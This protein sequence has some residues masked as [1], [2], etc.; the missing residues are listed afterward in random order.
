MDFYEV[1]VAAPIPEALTYSVQESE[2]SSLEAGTSVI[3]PL[4][5]RKAH[6]VV[7]RTTTPPPEI[8]LKSITA[9]NV[10]RPPLPQKHLQWLVWLSQYYFYPLGQVIDMAFPPLKRNLKPRKSSKSSI[11]P[12]L[13]STSPHP[14]L[15]SEQQTVVESIQKLS[16]FQ[17]HLV[18][19]VTGSGKTE[20]YLQLIARL[21]KNG[22]SALVLVPEI[23]LTPQLVSRFAERFPD[24]VA[25]IHSHLTEREKTDQ[26]WLAHTGER[27]VLIGARS[28]LFCPLPH[29]GMIILDEEHEPSF[30]QDE[31]LKYHARDAA[32]MLAKMMGIPIVLGSA[33]P[34]LETYQRARDGIYH[35]HTMKT[36]VQNR[37]LPIV[38]VVD[39]REARRERR[40]TE[41]PLPFWLSEPLHEE[42][43][44]TFQQG[45]QAALFLNRRGVAQVAMCEMCGFTYECPNCA[46]SL[47]V[48]KDH[49]LVCHYCDYAISLKP[50]CPSCHEGEV[51]PFGLGTEKIEK[52]VAHLFP[53]ARIARADRDEI[54]SRDD[55]VDL[56]SKME[57]GEID[58]LIGTQMIAKGLD[59]PKLTLVGLVVA[60]VGFHI[61]DFRATERSFQLI[62]Q[63]AGRA[64]RHSETPGRVLI[65]TYDPDHVSVTFAKNSQ[66]EPFADLELQHR[67]ML[68]YP[69]HGKLALIRFQGL[70][71]SDVEACARRFAERVDQLKKMD[72]QYLPIMVL[73]PAPSP[74]KR[75]RGKY[76][77]QCLTKSPDAK[78]LNILCRRVLGDGKWI[79]SGVRVQV[80]VD[81]MNML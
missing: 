19:G 57:K 36:R 44:K 51:E 59:F 61:P 4:G 39:L 45:E 58:I 48:H 80:D 50:D 72:P 18:F 26:W 35:L 66:F 14:S 40:E 3:V 56:I 33:T 31:K 63:V 25:V 13:Q 47:T 62:T 24:Q 52:D 78:L 1:A 54:Q 6:G 37:S 23:S 43:R 81:P 77:Y 8:Q 71:E 55:L 68:K 20:V 46:I 10:D 76:R 29:L 79:L 30:K 38:S 69:P 60:D 21:L 9:L 64:G 15:T 42:L 12:Q 53:T 16:G 73:G 27:R 67:H 74:L 32:M 28:A 2:I 65:Q 49:H 70:H 11:V 22:Q 5:S 34:S 75:L 7:V 41:N 17:T